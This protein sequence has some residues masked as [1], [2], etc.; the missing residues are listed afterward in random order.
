[1]LDLMYDVPDNDD[2]LAV[3]ITRPVVLEQSKPLIRRRQSQ[4]A[5]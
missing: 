4:A 1:M 5:A 2:I 3:K